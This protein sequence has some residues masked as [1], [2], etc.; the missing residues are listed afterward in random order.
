VIDKKSNESVKSIK[1]LVY[2]GLIWIFL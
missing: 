1:N 2:S